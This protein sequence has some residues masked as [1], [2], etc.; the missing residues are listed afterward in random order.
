MITVCGGERRGHGGGRMQSSAKDKMGGD[1][2]M[3]SDSSQD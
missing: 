2:L 1:V 3:W